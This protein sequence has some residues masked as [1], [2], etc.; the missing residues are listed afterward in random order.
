MGEA[1]VSLWSMYTV[2]MLFME[3]IAMC[4]IC[5]LKELGNIMHPTMHVCIYVNW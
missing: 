1:C 5:G 3:D 2:Y 4:H